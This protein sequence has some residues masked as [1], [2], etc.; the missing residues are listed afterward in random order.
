MFLLELFRDVFDGFFYFL[1][2]I[3]CVFAFFYVLGIV[4]DDK[5]EI[6][7]KKL[8]EKK[9]YDIESGKEAA[10]AA[11][12]TKQVLSVDDT[13]SDVQ[14]QGVQ[15]SGIG[16]QLQE[17]NKK[18][19]VPSVMV[20]NSSSLSQPQVQQPQVQMV[21]PVAQS[22]PLVQP[23]IQQP[24]VQMVQP[25]VQTQPLVQPLIQ[26]PKAQMVQPL[27]Q[28]QVVTPLVKQPQQ[29]VQGPVVQ[30]PQKVVAEPLIINSN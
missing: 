12:E 14:F 17:V 20:I 3:A 11:M 26:Q 29:Q 10:I 2:L 28:K 4:A 21:Q 18:E 23:L 1:Y 7:E 16:M 13:P 30:Q 25:V 15:D 27:V 22:Q 5:R 19:E 6:I 9:Q 24:Q 8:R